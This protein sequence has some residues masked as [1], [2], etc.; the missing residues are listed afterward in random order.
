MRSDLLFGLAAIVAGVVGI[1]ES[2]HRRRHPTYWWERGWYRRHRKLVTLNP[3][4]WWYTFRVRV[5]RAP[6]AQAEIRRATWFLISAWF[7]VAVGLVVLGVVI[8]RLD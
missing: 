2:I 3:E 6:T 1:L 5:G 8:L 7:S 4:Y